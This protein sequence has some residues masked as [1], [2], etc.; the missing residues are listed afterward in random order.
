MIEKLDF[1]N[2]ELFDDQGVAIIN[3]KYPRQN[4]FDTLEIDVECVRASDGIR[5]R[6]DFER[7]GY[8]IMQ[9]VWD[10]DRFNIQSWEEVY[11]AQSWRFDNN[12]KED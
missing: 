6:Y 12:I 9:P 7:D 4:K 5:L 2:I 10:D 3:V 1:H 8:S 11:F